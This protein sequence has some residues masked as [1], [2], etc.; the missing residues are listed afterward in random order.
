M[1][2]T[3]MLTR[4]NFLR[5]GTLTALGLSLPNLL[6]GQT[7]PGKAKA[8]I[9]IWL[10]GGPSHLDMWDPK[11]DAPAEVRGPF[12]TIDTDVSGV[13]VTDLLPHMA[14]R[15]KHVALVRSVTSPLG[16]H[17]FGAQ[18]MLT[19]YKPTPA[20]E[21]PTLGAIIAHER[22]AK[23]VLPPFIAVPNHDIGGRRFSPTG[24]L[25]AQ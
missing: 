8:C 9:L 10:D 13:R 3:T 6:R 17:N 19:G 22:Q 16:E 20:L 18:Y 12:S 15:L 14:Q 5:C 21:Y 11:P 24:Y 1:L 4:R 2:E 7:K 23:H 25:P